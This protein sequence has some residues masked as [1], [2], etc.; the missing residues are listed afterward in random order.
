M[1]DGAT[2]EEPSNARDNGVTVPMR[3]FTGLLL[4]LRRFHGPISAK[5]SAAISLTVYEISG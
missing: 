5:T 2:C 4:G 3:E 1:S